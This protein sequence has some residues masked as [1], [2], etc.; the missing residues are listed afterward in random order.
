MSYF[1]TEILMPLLC[2]FFV[3]YF[4]PSDRREVLAEVRS[5]VTLLMPDTFRGK[6]NENRKEIYMKKIFHIQS[7]YL[8]RAPDKSESRPPRPIRKQR[9]DQLLMLPG[10][11]LIRKVP[12]A[13]GAI[14]HRTRMEQ[15][16]RHLDVGVAD[17]A[18]HRYDIPLRSYIHST[19]RR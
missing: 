18:I 16:R 8:E 10:R 17:R 14:L 4:T 13:S 6:K 19:D 7:N 5:R 2:H 15:S 12:T 1:L 11:L 9:R 3:E